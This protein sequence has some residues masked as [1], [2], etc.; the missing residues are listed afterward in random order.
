MVIGVEKLPC[1]ERTEDL[2]T[3]KRP[4][5]NQLNRTLATNRHER[6]APGPRCEARQG[7]KGGVVFPPG[8]FGSRWGV[9]GGGADWGANRLL[10]LTVGHDDERA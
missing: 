8:H 6:R 7:R 2:G 10:T 5:I 9:D 3:R 4:A 1:G